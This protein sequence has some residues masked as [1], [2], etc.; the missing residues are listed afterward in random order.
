MDAGV[1]Q[2]VELAKKGRRL[3]NQLSGGEQERVAIARVVNNP[4]IILADEPAR[5]LDSATS[6]KIMELLSELN[7][8][9]QTIIMVTYNSENARY[10]RRMI[11]LKNGRVVE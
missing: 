6:K 8:E 7:S 3:P 1:L 5:N 10:A 9:G 11:Q 2:K 4:P